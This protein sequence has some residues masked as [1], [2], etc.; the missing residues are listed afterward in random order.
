MGICDSAV[1]KFDFKLGPIADGT[2]AYSTQ[3]TT[4]DENYD[5]SY[6]TSRFAAGALQISRAMA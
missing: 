6:Q 2:D 1:Q 4:S 5:V 3:S